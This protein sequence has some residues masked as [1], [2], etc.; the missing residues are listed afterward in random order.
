MGD[1]LELPVTVPIDGHEQ[2]LGLRGDGRCA[3]TTTSTGCVAVDDSDR[4]S[5][6]EI[7]VRQGDPHDEDISL[8]PTIEPGT[9]RLDQEVRRFRFDLDGHVCAGPGHTRADVVIGCRVSRLQPVRRVAL[10]GVPGVGQLYADGA[11][12]TQ[13]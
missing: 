2:R 5:R 12:S 7:A 9:S 11:A 10:A 4:L 1:R 13:S 6:D 8:H 3:H